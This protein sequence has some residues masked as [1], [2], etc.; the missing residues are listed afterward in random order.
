MEKQG[1]DVF[2]SIYFLNG[3]RFQYW[4]GPSSYP[5]TGCTV[6]RFDF[7]A[8]PRVFLAARRASASAIR[9]ARA[10]I[11]R[12]ART[13]EDRHLPHGLSR[14]VERTRVLA[15][16]VVDAH[17]VQHPRRQGGDL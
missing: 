1:C 6:V 8:R 12:Q 16:L 10:R 15:R 14:L 7:F 2:Y 5:H 17:A 11:A 9:D 13:R 3:V 4:L